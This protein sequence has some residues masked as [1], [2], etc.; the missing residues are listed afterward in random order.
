MTDISEFN[1][2]LLEDVRQEATQSGISETDAFFERL[3]SRLETEGEILATDRASYVGSSSGKTVRIDGIGG[4][5]KEAE[6]VLSVLAC[7]FRPDDEPVKMNAQEAKKYF[8]HLINFVAASR[9]EAF[10]AELMPESAEFGV[11]E[12]IASSWKSITKVKL[13]LITNSIFSARTDAVLAGRIADIPVTYNIWDLTRFHRYETSGQAREKIVVNFR[14]DFGSAIPA[15]AASAKGEV[16]ESY[17]AVISGDQLAEIY[18]KWGARLLES[19]VRSFLQ[20]RGAV[21]RGIRDTIKDEPDMFFSYNNGL[22]ATADEVDVERTSDG[23]KIISASNLQVVNGGQTTASLHAARRLSPEALQQVHVQMKLTVVPPDTPEDVV[24]N[25]SKYAN[26]QNRVNAADFFSNHPFHMRIEGY[27]RRILSPAA[28]GTNRE[29]KWF[30]ERARGQYMVERSKKT[31]AERRRFDLE[32]PKTQFFV[33]TD[34]AKIEMS[35]RQYPDTVSKGAQKNFSVFAQ[36]VGKEWERNSKRFDETWYRRLIA[37]IIIFRHLEKIVPKQSWYPGGYRAN[38]ITYAISKLAV[39]VD[40]MDKV[41]DL[42]TVW[43]HQFLTRDLSDALLLAAETAS[44]VITHPEAGVNNITEWAK[45][46]ACWAVL[47]RAEI[48]YGPEL[49]NC[50]VEPADAQSVQKEARRNEA[51]VSGI[52]AQARVV[53]AGGE[54]WS[55]LRSWGSEKRMF[56]PREDGVLRTCGLLPAKLPS[57]KQAIIALELLEKAREEG[58]VD[59]DAPRIKISTL[60]RPH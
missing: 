38:V 5:P 15:L 14:E 32:Y 54:F 10:R 16:L 28:E 31:Q 29:T 8:G 55:R 26:S 11:A 37:K 7:I 9:R 1:S 59:E 21:N 27:S 30:Y 52:E 48:D 45:K 58:Y 51:M 56:S 41:I 60:S 13:I 20:A 6:G 46:Q 47:Q 24:P 23:L 42:D 34:L 18:E 35:F 43:R 44:D 22:S 57:E 40:D 12:L 33:K 19:N 25:I 17:L 4:H 49:M 36:A 39:D 50:L 53:E 3:A 2:Q